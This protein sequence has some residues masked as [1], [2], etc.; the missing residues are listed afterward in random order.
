MLRR[1]GLLLSLLL[2]ATNQVWSAEPVLRVAYFELAPHVVANRAQGA[3]G[4]AVDFLQDIARR[5]GVQ[6]RFDEEALPLDRLLYQLRLGEV[7]I[8]LAL[9][10]SPEREQFLRFP[11]KPFFLMQPALMVRKESSLREIRSAA[12]LRKLS[13]GVYSQGYLSPLMRTPGLRIEKLHGSD[14]VA[15]NL[16]K[17]LKGRIDAA[18][19][20][21][22][23]DLESAALSLGGA[24]RFR[25]LLLPESSQGLYTAFSQK[26]DPELVRRYER[27][28]AASEP[29]RKLLERGFRR[30]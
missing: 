6:L 7:D 1:I 12:D 24:E 23:L 14:L 3:S 13:I 15:R 8:A 21:D 28:L 19:S 5:M 4:P 26:T 2:L 22:A 18:Y 17:M 20:P 10:K 16:E 30:D 25:L 11:G 27:A 29:Y 9:G